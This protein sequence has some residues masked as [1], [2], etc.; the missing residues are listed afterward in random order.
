[1]K[2]VLAL[3]LAAIMVMALCGVAFADAADASTT[4]QVA[5]F[6]VSGIAADNT[7]TLYKIATPMY[8]AT[9]ND[10]TYEFVSPLTEADFDFASDGYSF[11]A[12]SDARKKADALAQQIIDGTL[13]PAAN[14]AMVADEN[15]VASTTNL[16]AGY[17]V[18][19]VSGTNSTED[20]YQHLLINAM[21]VV[22]TETKAYKAAAD[23]N[24][25]MK[26]TT[27]DITKGVTDSPD[28][29]VDVQT[30]DAYTVGDSVPYEI[31]TNIP[32]YPTPS[33]YAKFVITDTP[34]NLTDTVSTV[35]VTVDGDSDTGTTA[36]TITGKF[37]VAATADNGFT[38][39]F[40]KDY[41]LAHPGAAVTVNYS[42]VITEAAL[43]NAETG[44]TADN[45]AKITFNPNPNIDEE[46]EPDDKTEDY[47]YGLDVYKYEEGDINKA[48]TGAKFVLYAQDGTTVV[49]DET[50]VDENGHISWNKLKA[51]TYY[52][53]ETAAPTGYRLDSTP[54]EIVISSTTANGNDRTT[55]DITET[56]FLQQD[57]A[58]TPGASLPSTGGIGTTIFYVTGLIMVLGASVILVSRRRADAK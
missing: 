12:T 54:K 41:I 6:S 3:A 10:L 25:V 31:K 39:T 42:A 22:N 30:T 35:I 33:T 27:T 20:I 14:V 24:F 18:G 15:G 17:Y 52:L 56:F 21:P 38:V 34:R 46:V 29:S 16:P 49:K 37:T 4:Y 23:M 28:H 36:G 26:K 51:G 5:S 48:L 1:M 40:D 55:D 19:I 53:V 44:L 45:T 8:D 11:N 58:N 7:L 2:K 13:S 57:V 9:A 43:L 50:E 47:T 32:N